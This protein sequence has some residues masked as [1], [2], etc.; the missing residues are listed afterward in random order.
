MEQTVSLSDTLRVTLDVTQNTRE[1]TSQVRVTG[2][3]VR[4]A[5]QYVGSCWMACEIRLDGALGANLIL[6][7]T[8]GCSFIYNGDWH[9]G[10]EGT[11][12]GFSTQAQTASH[13]PD[14]T[15]T[16]TLSVSV[17]VY[18]TGSSRVGT[19]R[20]ETAVPLPRIPRVSTLSAAPVELGEVMELRL[21]RAAAEFRDTVT[22]QC[23]SQQG[24]LAEKTAETILCWTPP[25]ALAAQQTQ[26]VTVPITFTV[27]TYLEETAL[28]SECVTVQCA[29]PAG[30]KPQVTVTVADARGYLQQYGGYVRTQSQ[31]EVTTAAIGPYGAAIR[32]ISVQ[33]GDLTGNG[34]RVCFA[35]ERSGEIPVEV[36]VTDSRGR[37]AAARK[38]ISVLS[39]EKPWA[40]LEGAFRCSAQGESQADGAYLCI[41]FRAGATQLTGSSVTYRAVCRAK[42][43]AAERRVLLTAYTDQFQVSGSAVLPAGADTAYDCA[44][45][46][47][48]SFQT[49]CS[50]W[51]S[52]AVAFA[53]LDFDRSAKAVGIGM[54][55]SQPNALSLGLDTSLSQHRLTDLAEPT[56]PA[57]AATKA[58]VDRMLQ[59]LE[60]R[61]T[62]K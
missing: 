30:V 3:E 11:W 53:L 50:A 27:Q 6:T 7:N 47:T 59:E 42:D 38:T 10:G 14:G 44:V 16:V 15:G 54:R 55:A 2:I 31:A 43:T 12:S 61:L 26:D 58:Y 24:T 48:D 28:G 37:T 21:E 9:G 20:Q 29:I 4:T 13:A 51:S 32:N 45:E 1:N 18:T 49:Q 56:D 33:C 39:Y 25:A 62:E 46:V 8:R 22:W 5:G 41:R 57:D 52:V 60:T 36:L 35:L 17:T 19:L 40:V 23:G 34:E